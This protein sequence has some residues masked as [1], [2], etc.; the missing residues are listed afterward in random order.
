MRTTASGECGESEGVRPER[1]RPTSQICLMQE[2]QESLSTCMLPS[3]SS[4]RISATAAM[5][6]KSMD[7]CVSC[8]P[9]ACG[10]SRLRLGFPSHPSLGYL[11]DPPCPQS[12]WSGRATSVL[13]EY[14]GLL[15]SRR[16]LSCA[17]SA[18]CGFC[19]AAFDHMSVNASNVMLSE[20]ARTAQRGGG[21]MD[22]GGQVGL[23]SGSGSVSGPGLGLKELGGG[24]DGGVRGGDGC[25]C[26]GGEGGQRLGGDGNGGGNGRR[27]GG[28]GEGGGGEGGG[29]G[30]GEGKGSGSGSGSGLGSGSACARVARARA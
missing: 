26:G 18:C 3:G 10:P 28:G 5:E 11:K 7:L 16:C 6:H 22:L 14:V 12:F 29:D 8:V 23:G 20:K 21:H 1:G 13:L 17:A 27:L 2:A 24:E 9:Q 30:G 19:C 15:R 4:L 25:G